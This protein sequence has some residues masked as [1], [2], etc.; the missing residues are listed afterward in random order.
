ML[1]ITKFILKGIR[2]VIIITYELM[3]ISLFLIFFLIQKYI[4]IYTSLGL[5][6][7]Y[8]IIYYREILSRYTYV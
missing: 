4:S 7:I 8:K 3:L 5:L 2:Y 1:L 6:S